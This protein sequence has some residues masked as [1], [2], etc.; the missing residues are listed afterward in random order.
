[1]PYK[2]PEEHRKKQ[3]A[4]QKAWRAIPGNAE[5][6]RL[7]T[8]RW[9]EANPGKANASAN[10]SNRK[11]RVAV[12][13]AYGGGCACCGEDEEKFLAIDHV[14]GGGNA[15]REK[16]FG[17]KNISGPMMYRWLRNQGYPKDEFQLLCHNCNIGKHHNGGICPHQE[18]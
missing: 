13:E 18:E 16:I 14:N 1:M 3:A 7:C 5:R 10:A 2:H 11:L 4:Y 6:Q 15:H 8:K 9:R 17:K 12:L